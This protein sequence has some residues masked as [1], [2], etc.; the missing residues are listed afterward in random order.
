MKSLGARLALLLLTAIVLVVIISSFVASL[1]MRGPRP[2]MTMEPVAR[3]LSI[4][5]TFAEKDKDAAVSSGL[6]IA[7]VPARGPRDEHLS[8]VL[9]DAL[10]R[11]AE[12][13]EAIISRPAP[14]DT[15][16]SLRLSDGKWM[17]IPMPEFGPPPGG[18]R[19]LMGWIGLIITGSVLVSIFAASKIMKPLRMLERAVAEIGP[20]GTLPHVPETGPGEIRVTAQALNGLSARVKAA[21]ESRMRLVAAA[22]HDLRTPMTRMRL[23]AEFIKDDE[24]RRKWLADLEELDTIADSAIGLVR[25]EISSDGL[26]CVRLDTIVA[27][28]VDELSAIGMNVRSEELQAASISAGPLA[29]TR[30]LRN[31]LIN[32]ATHGES[33]IV[34]VARFADRAVVRIVDTG[35]GIPEERLNQVFEPFFRIDI[36]R[37]RSF[38]GAGLGMAIAKEIISRFEGEIVVRNR[39]PR[40]L[41]QLITFN[42][43][44]RSASNRSAS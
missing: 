22:G 40:G 31:L 41:E 37:Q 1:V 13:R 42:S 24:D 28:I 39:E 33:A 14:G 9:M 21:T 8:G 20:D 32:A 16:A 5:A 12:A 26:Q 15:T 44:G 30:A 18:W 10:S 2:D 35:P 23:R 19:I 3:Q 17:V 38:P 7:A 25:E 27:D 34:T 11:I 29:V 36:A 4:L 43:P 6:D